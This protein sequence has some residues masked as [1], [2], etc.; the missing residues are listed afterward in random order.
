MQGCYFE[1]L[2]N[3]AFWQQGRHLPTTKGSLIV[4]HPKAQS[5]HG[6]SPAPKGLKTSGRAT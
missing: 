5:M 6:L 4:A 1:A 2:S 3:W